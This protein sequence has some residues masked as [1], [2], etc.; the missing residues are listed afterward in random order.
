MGSYF[1]HKSR[2]PD[3][4]VQGPH[5]P[6]DLQVLRDTSGEQDLRLPQIRVN[7]NYQIGLRE[8]GHELGM[9]VPFPPAPFVRI[10]IHAPE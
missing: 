4:A 1:P 10:A 8:W 5:K 7:V 2:Y 3:Q 9:S 6:G